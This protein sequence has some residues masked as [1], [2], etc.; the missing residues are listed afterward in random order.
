MLKPN[1]YALLVGIKNYAPESNVNP[2]SG[3][4]NDVERMRD[5][6]NGPYAGEFKSR[7]IEVLK[8]PDATYVNVI[9]YFYNKL[10]LQAKPGDI[11]LFH[12]CGH[13]SFCPTAQELIAL[14]DS[15]TQDETL[16]CF[17]SR[18]EGHYDLADK[19]LAALIAQF[20]PGVDVVVIAD[21][22]YSGSITRDDS[23]K[24]M[25]GFRERFTPP[26]PEHIRIL[27]TYFHGITIPI[28]REFY[29]EEKR[30]AGKLEI[31]AARH[32]ALMACSREQK[33]YE[34][35]GGGRFTQ[36][37]LKMLKAGA[38]RHLSYRALFHN[39][40]ASVDLAEGNLQTP[41]FASFEDFNAGQFFLKK[42]AE[43]PLKE[44]YTHY[45][46]KNKHWRVNA[47]AFQGLPQDDEVT[48]TGKACFH[49]YATHEVDPMPLVAFVKSVHPDYSILDIPDLRTYRNH[50]TFDAALISLPVPST[51][52]YVTGF[53]IPAEQFKKWVALKMSLIFFTND[54]AEARYKITFGKTD[55][56]PTAE[57]EDRHLKKLL[58]RFI[59]DTGIPVEEIFE[60]ILDIL[61]ALEKWERFLPV[62]NK[63]LQDVEW[64]INIKDKNN[65]WKKISDKDITLEYDNDKG[66]SFYISVLNKSE[67]KYYLSIVYADANRYHYRVLST[68]S[69]FEIGE[70]QKNV[71]GNRSLPK[72]FNTK[73]PCKS[74]SITL[75]ESTTLLKLIASQN[76][77]TENHL[78]T[79]NSPFFSVPIGEEILIKTR[80]SGEEE[81]K[82]VPKKK[83]GETYFV[84]NMK[85]KI[86]NLQG[87]L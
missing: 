18:L 61:I 69:S 4:H 85:I 32:I 26:P 58:R 34:M 79:N 54:E 20:E 74:G 72:T 38:G 14:S 27:N 12:Y 3:A 47:G 16:V 33:A 55:T 70:E 51:L 78:L 6:L 10:C 25:N 86:I 29:S 87:T 81:K 39:L 66:I 64:H 28:L 46:D 37:M 62:E 22:C 19:E 31:P 49:L 75:P 41:A 8:D 2:L 71:Y 76:P 48:S 13:G 67:I 21:S 9:T 59:A 77:I 73:I 84:E 36:T 11:A 30:A 42:E 80:R 82:L 45:D 56:G 17:D 68:V 57:V 83:P 43:D 24:E 50:T 40:R 65:Q 60:E 52:F 63:K 53:K 23:I 5:F 44:F 7:H 15:K 35:V 1:L